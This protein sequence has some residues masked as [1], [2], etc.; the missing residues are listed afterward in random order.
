[1]ATLF[2]VQAITLRPQTS[3]SSALARVP[4]GQE[5]DR[6]R[7]VAS[8]P[9]VGTWESPGSVDVAE[10][11]RGSSGRVLAWVEGTSEVDPTESTEDSIRQR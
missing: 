1:M 5:A 10:P 3:I 7:R 6:P 4:A 11:D 9:G 8:I 2:W